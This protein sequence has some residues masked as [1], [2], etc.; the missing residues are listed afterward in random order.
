MSR[1]KPPGAY[2]ILLFCMCTMAFPP[3]VTMIPSFLLL[4]Q[5]PAIGLGMAAGCRAFS[6]WVIHRLAP[7][8]AA[9]KGI[10]A[11][12]IGLGV[13]FYLLPKLFGDDAV[14]VSLLNT[15]W[16]LILPG[17]GEW[18]WHFPTQGVF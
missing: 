15:F 10:T 8:G 4:K 1:Y 6:A 14:D 16:A 5:F 2:K 7:G 9:F 18:V 13:G 17:R 3:E 11:G 12:V